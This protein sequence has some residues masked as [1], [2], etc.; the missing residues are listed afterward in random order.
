MIKISSLG[1]F[2]ITETESGAVLT[3]A[4]LRSDMLKKLFIYM[5]L[6]RDHSVSVAELSDALWVEDET[7]N[8]QG[9]LKNLMYRMRTSLK[10]TFGDISF[11]NTNL[12]SYSFNN[13]LKVSVD[14]EE[15]ESLCKSAKRTTDSK[16]SIRAYEK[17]VSLYK[18][19]FFEGKGDRNWI[20]TSATFYHSMFLTS[21]KSLATL[22]ME[23]SE[24][25][26]AETVLNTGL[27]YDNVDETL[28]CELIRSLIK[29]GNLELA[30]EAFEN[31]KK[32]MQKSLGIRESKNLRKVHEELLKMSKGTSAES[33][34]TIHEDMVEKD[35]PDGAFICGYPAFREIYRLESRKSSRLGEAEYVLLL[36][37]ECDGDVET[38]DNAYAFL[39][40]RAMRHLEESVKHSL[41]IGDV[42]AK[43]SD[44]QYVV[45]LPTCTYETSQMVAERVIDDFNRAYK[46]NG[47]SIIADFEE[48]GAA[49]AMVM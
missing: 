41:R 16:A 29:Q 13:D 49:S 19:E 36:T 1:T 33:L 23:E 14:A 10:K 25:K 46:G 30:S 9:A 15:F 43:Y 2:S 12:G 45:L 37:V 24:Y 7:D 47:I 8:P 38:S 48:I 42:A 32:I 28:H 17:A 22:Y 44:S 39:I 35:D 18:G 21:V 5:V 27:R 4:E 34:S 26:K 40:N 31:A 3:D 6:H 11:F 20:V